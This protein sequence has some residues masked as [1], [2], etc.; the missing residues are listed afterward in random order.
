M[1]PSSLRMTV[2]WLIIPRFCQSSGRI[3]LSIWNDPKKKA[4]FI[5]YEVSLSC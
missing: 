2:K 3:G 1:L 5:W 4:T